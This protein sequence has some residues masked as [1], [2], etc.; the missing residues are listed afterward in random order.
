M[1]INRRDL[2]KRMLAAGAI[3]AAAPLVASRP[4]KA[5]QFGYDRFTQPIFKP[6][7]IPQYQ[8]MTPAPGSPEA[9]L[10][11]EAVFHGIAPEFNCDHPCHLQD[12]DTDPLQ[13][14]ELDT[15]ETVWEFFP[16]VNT[17]VFAYKGADG[18]PSETPA[19]FPGPTFLSRFQ[20]GLVVRNTNR[21]SVETSV[22]LHGTHGPAHSDGFPDFYVLQDK[23]RDYYYPNIAPR[24]NACPSEPSPANPECAGEFEV[25]KI[26]T[27]LW[28]HDHAM[29]VTG[30]NVNRGLA[31][32]YLMEDEIEIEHQQ[33][34]VLPKMYG[35]FDQVLCLKDFSFNSDG[36]L[37]YDLL[38]HNGHIGDVF[39]ANGRVQPYMEVYRKKYRFRLLNACNARMLHLRL[40]S[41]AGRR[42][43]DGLPFLLL[44][45]DAWQRPYAENMEEFTIAPGERFDI[46]IDFSQL[47]EDVDTYYLQ[48]IM[49]QTD[50]RK[51]KGIR[52][53]KEHEPWL[54]FRI[55]DGPPPMEDEIPG[56]TNGEYSVTEGTPLRPYVA[57]EESEVVQT[58]VFDFG[59]S[60][61]AWQVNDLFFSPRRTDAA[62]LLNSCEHWIIRN[63]SGGW[64]HPI[65][66]H[67]EGFQVL[68]IN[69]VYRDD[70]DFP[71]QYKH[72]CDVVNLEG[73]QEAEI[74]IKFRTFKGPFV[75]HCHILEH[76]D[77]RMMFVIDPREAGEPSMND[78]IR[79]HSFSPEAALNSGMPGGCIDHN[80]LLFDHEQELQ[81][82]E[83]VGPG[84][85][86]QLEGR[87]VGFPTGYIDG[88]EVEGAGDW[89]PEGNQDSPDSSIPE[90]QQP[91]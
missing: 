7:V 4:V 84:N 9:S 44:G 61:G 79:N 85:Y 31:G 17:P 62:P 34:G 49:H 48:N 86:E 41:S 59:R 21:T 88:V 60:N 91:R 52:P 23:A 19:S 36:T 67:L 76:E 73:G 71:I 51:P 90:S 54:Q 14:A 22:H 37:R 11:S 72:N 12:W 68:R 42:Q 6:P 15:V 25:G 2:L 16:G 82:G 43:K 13:C 64:W 55:L 77:M 10:G 53:K 56:V 46:V 38:D 45:K 69:D 78:G 18:S 74:M 81:S 5:T 32:F 8:G 47:P 80:K 58:R 75:S 40:S 70:P 1:A 33:N 89:D 39:T 66:I 30:F 24:L 26:P 83:V 35:E 63:G 57:Y 50:G 27:T 3:G 29:D 65:H 87:G 20:Q 28:Y